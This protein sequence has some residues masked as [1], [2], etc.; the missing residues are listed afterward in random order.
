MR[1]NPAQLVVVGTAQQPHGDVELTIARVGGVDFILVDDAHSHLVDPARMIHRLE[2]RHHHS[3]QAL[4][5]VRIDA[6]R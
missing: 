4:G 6:S 2:K 1:Q 3:T 5:L